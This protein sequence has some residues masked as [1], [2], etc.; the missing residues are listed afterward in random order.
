MT[1]SCMWLRKKVRYFNH[2]FSKLFHRNLILRLKHHHR[3]YVKVY[4]F[5]EVRISILLFDLGGHCGWP[6]GWNPAAYGHERMSSFIIEFMDA[7]VKMKSAE[8]E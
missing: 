5:S 6:C 3:F 7:V 8:K 4:F 2:Y 1:T